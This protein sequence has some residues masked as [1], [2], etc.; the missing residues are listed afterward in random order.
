[1]LLLLAG[2]CSRPYACYERDDGED[3]RCRCVA[4]RRSSSPSCLRKYDCCVEFT[5]GSILPD[6]P[7]SGHGC[8]CWMLRPG[9][10]LREYV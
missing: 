7:N 3:A 2:A 4:A 8:G 6:D 10:D 5:K 9:T 1:L